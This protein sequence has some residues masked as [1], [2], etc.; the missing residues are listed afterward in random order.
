MQADWNFEGSFDGKEWVV[1]HAA[2]ED[3]SLVG[4]RTELGE[5]HWIREAIQR[6]QGQTEKGKIWLDY[7]ERFQ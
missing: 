5:P 3:F 6:A 2:R 7:M 1:L 4:N